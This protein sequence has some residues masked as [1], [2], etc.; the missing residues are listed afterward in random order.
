MPKKKQVVEPV[1]EVIEPTVVETTIDETVLDVSVP[2]DSTPHEAP[3]PAPVTDLSTLP[4]DEVKEVKVKAKRKAQPKK[5]EVK[6]ISEVEAPINI[7]EEPKEITEELKKKVKTLEQ[8]QCDTCEKEMTKRTLRYH[9]KCPGEVVKREE[10]PVK[11]RVK[12][13]TKKEDEKQETT[14]SVDERPR[15]PQSIPEKP[16]LMNTY[17]ERLQKALEKRSQTI[18]KL[19][20]QIV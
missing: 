1:S 5:I 14:T 10:L 20:S 4:P 9:H 8:V 12:K 7:P 13:E 3:A 6:E 19:A 2:P 16:V 17:Q 11:K 18:Q 15:G